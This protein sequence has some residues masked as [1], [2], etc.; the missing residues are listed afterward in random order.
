LKEFK[1][2][3]QPDKESID[4]IAKKANLTSKQVYDW[5]RHKRE[6]LNDFDVD[7]KFDLN[8]RKK[9]YSFRIRNNNKKKRVNYEIT[10]GKMK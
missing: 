7:N 2:N 1:Q 6:K 5:F 8:F 10:N 4:R 3:E 9:Q